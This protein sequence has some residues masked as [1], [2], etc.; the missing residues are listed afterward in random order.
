[1]QPGQTVLLQGTGGVS[2][3]G[4]QIAHAAGAKTNVT[5]SSDEKLV[6]A[7]PLGATHT[8]H[9]CPISFRRHLLRHNRGSRL[10]SPIPTACS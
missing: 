7:K 10:G 9:R 1:M 3:F 4:L 5:S 6:K 8:I 2:K